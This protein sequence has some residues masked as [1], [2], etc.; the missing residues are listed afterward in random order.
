MER[1]GVRLWG[2]AGGSAAEKLERLEEREGEGDRGRGL[3]IFLIY[4][5]EK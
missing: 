5:T 4:L 1:G 2:R 3:T